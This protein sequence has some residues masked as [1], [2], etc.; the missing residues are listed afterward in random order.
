MY[1]SLRLLIAVSST[2]LFPL[3]LSADL[4]LSYISSASTTNPSATANDTADGLVSANLQQSG[5]LT[6]H[7][8]GS[9]NWEGWD[10]A[11][12]SFNEAVT[13]N[14]SW[15]FGFTV[16]ATGVGGNV[17]SV[18]LTTLSMRVDRSGSGPN[19]IELRAY[20]NGG[21]ETSIFTHGYDDTAIG[22]TFRDLDI[23]SI[24]PLSVGD[25]IQFVFAGFNSE[26]PGG[27]MDLE[28]LSS[29]NGIEVNGNV[30]FSSVPEPTSLL[31]FGA[32]AL[33]GLQRRRKTSR[34]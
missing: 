19:D 21:S 23:S 18:D 32:T 15:T 33:I 29:G 14:D 9:F 16:G 4:V 13:A 30:N 26:W 17:S 27:T 25:T 12:T 2:V 11:N 1:N 28:N 7:T 20:V 31:M 10:T 22:R 34:S 6:A 8:G 3:N 24:G 5:G